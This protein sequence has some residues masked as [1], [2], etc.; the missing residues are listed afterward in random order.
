M[1]VSSACATVG[2]CRTRQSVR[3]SSQDWVLAVGLNLK[4]AQRIGLTIPEGLLIRAD[5]VID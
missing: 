5:K 2:P 3:Q 1:A 4:T